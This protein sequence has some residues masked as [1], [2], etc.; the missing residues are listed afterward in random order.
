MRLLWLDDRLDE[1]QAHIAA[2]ERRSME[3][4]TAETVDDALSKMQR[5]VFDV[6]I[7]DLLLPP[8]RNNPIELIEAIKQLAPHSLIVVV[9]GYLDND[10]YRR[11]LSAFELMLVEKPL[12]EVDSERFAG[13]V[14][15]LEATV[16]AHLLETAL[17]S[18]QRGRATDDSPARRLID[19]LELKP[20]LF[21]VGIDL[22]K[23]FSRKDL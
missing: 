11:A 6:V 9:S 19:A 4:T 8:P 21:G 7:M 2:L 18:T 16:S 3:V 10:E 13:F 22:K 12:P 17:P 14:H 1:L 23:L 15:K 20:R 5:T